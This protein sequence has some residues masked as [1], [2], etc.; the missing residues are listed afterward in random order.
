MLGK[1]IEKV[2]VY[3]HSMEKADVQYFKAIRDYI[4]VEIPWEIALY[5]K[6]D[7]VE[8]RKRIGDFLGT[9]DKIQYVSADSVPYKVKI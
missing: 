7:S 6:A 8:N 4:G 5:G 1:N 2:R 9:D 3:G